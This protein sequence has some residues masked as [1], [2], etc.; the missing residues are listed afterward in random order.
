MLTVVL[1]LVN[2]LGLHNYRAEVGEGLDGD[3]VAFHEPHKTPRYLR[4]CSFSLTIIVAQGPQAVHEEP[5]IRNHLQ[6]H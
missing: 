4:D 1:S 6:C 5:F 3:A 2:R